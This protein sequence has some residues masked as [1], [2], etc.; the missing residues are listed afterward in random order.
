MRRTGIAET[1]IG[2]FILAILA[3]ITGWVYFAQSLFDPDFYSV[4]LREKDNGASRKNSL[5]S[6]GS[7]PAPAFLPENLV[8]MGP[9]ET[10]DTETLSEKIDGKAELYLSSGF[11]KLRTR[12]F[13]RKEDPKSWLELFI[14]EM[15][16]PTNAFS[17]YSSQ[18]RKDSRPV[19]LGVSAYATED[20]FFL[21][22][23]PNYF[24]IISANKDL[25]EEMNLLAKNL[26]DAEP[27]Y[28]EQQTEASL[29]PPESLDESSISLH[30]SDVFGFSALDRVYTAGYGQGTAKVTA[31]LS[32]RESTREA[33]DLAAAYGR[34]L[35]ENGG[36]EAGEIPGA[37][38][39]RIYKVFDTYEVVLHRGKFLAGTHEADNVES[40]TDVASRI[41]HKLNEAGR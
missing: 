13:A 35:L 12:R 34:F 16:D 8:P 21:T 3:G 25:G 29:F 27:K 7:V 6:P 38:D 41:Y 20:A 2:I 31:F 1:C 24:E 23:G 32:K 28:T 26:V 40:A 18:K 14:Y 10:F 33:A 15:G 5:P 17:V 36:E 30:M 37:P 19:N 11:E 39:S 4:T 22:N 9:E